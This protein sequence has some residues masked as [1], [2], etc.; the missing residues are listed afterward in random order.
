MP[1]NGHVRFGGR[2]AETHQPQDWQGAAVRP[3]HL[4]GDLVGMGYVAFV[5]DVFSRAHHRL[6]DPTLDADR[7]ISTAGMGISKRPQGKR[8]PPSRGSCT[9]PMPGPNTPDRYTERLARPGST[10]RRLV[11]DSYDNALAES[12]IGLFKTGDPPEAVA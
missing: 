3:L 12:R 6:A 8:H 7:L 2:A 10:L 5:L 11:G 9:T 1:R 4:R